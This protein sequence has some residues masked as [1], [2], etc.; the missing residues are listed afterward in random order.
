[1]GLLF[2]LVT[3]VQT[4]YG[5]HWRWEWKLFSV[6]LKTRAEGLRVMATVA[7]RMSGLSGPEQG[8]WAKKIL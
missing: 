4:K 8:A 5:Q 6:V 1:M 3:V 2:A 7:A